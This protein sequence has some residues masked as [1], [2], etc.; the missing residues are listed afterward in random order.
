MPTEAP[1]APVL[2]SGPAQE[3]SA[4]PT[5]LEAVGAALDHEMERDPNVFIIGEDVGQFGGACKVTKG[6]LDK[7]GPRRVVATRSRSPRARRPASAGAGSGA[8]AA[9]P[10]SHARTMAES[11]APRRQHPPGMQLSR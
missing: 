8:A 10:C 5:Y 9:R 11:A 4:N 7:S 6:F 1:P 3:L 2:K